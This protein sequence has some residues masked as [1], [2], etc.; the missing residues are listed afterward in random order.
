[1]VKVCSM[2]TDIEISVYQI[3]IVISRKD[4]MSE[5]MQYAQ[6]LCNSSCTKDGHPSAA[7]GEFGVNNAGEETSVFPNSKR[8]MV[9]TKSCD[10]SLRKKCYKLI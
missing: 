7:I 3:I 2:L 6:L 8:K 5:T 9:V 1:M 4:S 10:I